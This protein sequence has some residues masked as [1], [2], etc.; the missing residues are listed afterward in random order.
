MPCKLTVRGTGDVGGPALR[1]I[2]LSPG[3]DLA[4]VLVPN[5]EEALDGA[6]A[7]GARIT[8][9]PG[10]GLAGAEDERGDGGRPAATPRPRTS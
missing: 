2:V 8:G 5:P 10:I 9:R 3:L 6:G 1:T 4:R 7:R